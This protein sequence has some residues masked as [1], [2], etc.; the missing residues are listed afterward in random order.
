MAA[1]LLRPAALLFDLDGTL[2]DSFAG[3][4]HALN[5]ALRES[6]LPEFDLAWVRTHVG[7]GAVGAG[8]SPTVSIVADR[9]RPG[10]SGRSSWRRPPTPGLPRRRGSE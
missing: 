10:S 9:P 3:I 4:R 6:G 8:V 2:A 5:A 7:R 1:E